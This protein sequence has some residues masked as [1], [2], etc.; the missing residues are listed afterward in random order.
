MSPAEAL[1]AATLN[2][3]YA[4]GEGREA[5]SLEVGKRADLVL[6]SVRDHREIPYWFGANLVRQVIQAGQLVVDRKGA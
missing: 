2:A 6:W 4:C 3:A 5:G 1:A